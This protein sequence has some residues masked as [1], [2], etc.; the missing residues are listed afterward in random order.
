LNKPNALPNVVLV[1]DWWRQ[2]KCR[3]S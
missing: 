3:P 1:V 2:M